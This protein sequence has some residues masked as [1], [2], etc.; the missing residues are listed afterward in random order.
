V[1]D[2]DGGGGGIEA[3]AAELLPELKKCADV[4]AVEFKEDPDASHYVRMLFGGEVQSGARSLG[5][6]RIARALCNLA[7][8]LN[9]LGSFQGAGEEIAQNQQMKGQ[10]ADA[11]SAARLMMQAHP[12]WA[13]PMRSLGELD[14]GRV[15]RSIQRHPGRTPNQLQ[16]TRILHDLGSLVKGEEERPDHDRPREEWVQGVRGLE[17]PK[18]KVDIEGLCTRVQG[19]VALNHNHQGWIEVQEQYGLGAREAVQQAYMELQDSELASGNYSWSYAWDFK[20]D[21]K[22]VTHAQPSIVWAMLMW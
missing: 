20:K 8:L 13:L 15:I 22:Q 18:R 21:E 2:A 7:D 1:A 5:P 10:L 6:T 16:I 9:L 11:R 12:G 14:E 17:P 3:A 4:F 19:E